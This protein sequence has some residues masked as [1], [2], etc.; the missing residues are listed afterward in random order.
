MS[1]TEQSKT[2][3]KLG[4]LDA[5]VDLYQKYGFGEELKA[6]MELVVERLDKLS[7]PFYG[8]GPAE[9]EA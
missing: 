3:T 1:I 8:E 9:E 7:L 2:A 4:L 6:G 5:L